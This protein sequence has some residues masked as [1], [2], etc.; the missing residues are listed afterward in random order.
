M[1]GRNNGWKGSHQRRQ[2]GLDHKREK[3]EERGKEE[4]ME[5]RI[6]SA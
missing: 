2:T 3:G 5:S 4:K 6:E 1:E